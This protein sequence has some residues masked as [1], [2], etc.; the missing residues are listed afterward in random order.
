[1]ALCM[2]AFGIACIM[3]GIDHAVVA[4]VAGVLGGLIGYKASS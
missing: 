2:T 3:H 4:A 1:V